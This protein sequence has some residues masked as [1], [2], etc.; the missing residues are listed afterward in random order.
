MKTIA[1]DQLDTVTGGA[2]AVTA[3]NSTTLDQSAVRAL[4]HLGREIGSVANA[5]Q[6]ASTQSQTMLLVA[7]LAS[8]R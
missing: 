4:R 8:R 1:I 6:Q 2:T 7:M 3:N 5:Q